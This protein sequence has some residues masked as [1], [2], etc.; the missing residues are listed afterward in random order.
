M[1]VC[2]LK[3]QGDSK[4]FCLYLGRVA[5]AMASAGEISKEQLRSSSVPVSLGNWC[6]KCSNLH[7]LIGYP[8]LVSAWHC[9]IY[10]MQ[11]VLNSVQGTV[12]AFDHQSSSLDFPR[13][14]L[15]RGR[16]K[17][18][19]SKDLERSAPLCIYS[20]QN[21]SAVRNRYTF[22][23]YFLQS[24]FS[25]S[26]A[27]GWSSLA[28]RSSRSAWS[29]SF[30]SAPHAGS[31][32]LAAPHACAG[33]SSSSGSSLTRSNLSWGNGGHLSLH[34]YILPSCKM[35][36]GWHTIGIRLVYDWHTVVYDW[37][38]W[39]TVMCGVYDG[40]RC[41]VCTVYD[42]IRWHTVVYGVTCVYGIRWHTVAYGGIRVTCGYGIRLVYDWYTIGIRWYTGAPLGMVYDR[43]TIWYT[44]VVLHISDWKVRWWKLLRWFLKKRVIKLK[45]RDWYVSVEATRCLP[46]SSSCQIGVLQRASLDNTARFP[47]AAVAAPAP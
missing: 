25:W 16:M 40:I 45:P 42:G 33:S 10:I 21:R 9:G 26:P 13:Y 28:W 29:S 7:K 2:R 1:W 23:K 38:T 6:K 44:D 36:P 14:P 35:N 18:N 39:Y 32:E 41:Y 4:T 15:A 8:Y 22:Q 34:I 11:A 27:D 5:V 31:E 17:L 37:H 3:N 24:R 47:P 43:Y 30:S 12:P 46:L 20:G 19:R